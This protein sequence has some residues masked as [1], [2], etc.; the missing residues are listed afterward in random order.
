MASVPRSRYFMFFG[1]AVG[2]TLADLFTKY[3]AFKQL[4]MPGMREKYWLI[5]PIFAFETSLNEGALFGIGQGKVALFAIL[6]VVAAIAIFAWLFIAGAAR[7]RLLTFTM[8][9]VTAGIFGNLYDRLGMH[10]LEW[11]GNFGSHQIGEPVYAVRDFIVVMLG[12]YQWPNFNIADCCLV[13]GAILLAWHAL[14]T[15]EPEEDEGEEG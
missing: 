14:F 4:G 12:T 7:D 5:E 6:S 10:A 9:L 13:C 1:L 2:G 11:H 3:W 8:G 15:K